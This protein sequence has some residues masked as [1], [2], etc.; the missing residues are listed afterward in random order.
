MHSKHRRYKYNRIQQLLIE[1]GNLLTLLRLL[2]V[3]CCFIRLFVERKDIQCRR[4][5]LRRFHTSQQLA[6]RTITPSKQLITCRHTYSLHYKI[7]P[8]KI[9]LSTLPQ[10]ATDFNHFHSN[11]TNQIQPRNIKRKQTTSAPVKEQ[12]PVNCLSTQHN[13]APMHPVH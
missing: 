11:S 8:L 12:T 4:T 10:S 3:C 5:Q 7:V 6:H 9:I 13:N 2:F 1:Y